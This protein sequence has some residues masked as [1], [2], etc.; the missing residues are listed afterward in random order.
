LKRIA[1]IH[2]PN[3]FPWL[4][5]FDKI[6]RADAFIFLDD[7]Q[8]AKKGG[9]WTNRVKLQISGEARWITAPVQRNFHGSKTINEMKFGAHPQWR[10]K[11]LKSIRAN[12]CSAPYY[13]EMISFFQEVIGNEESNVAS[14]N[15]RAILEIAK[16]LELNTDHIFWSSKLEHHGASNEL[17][18]SLTKAVGADTYLFGGGAGGYQDEQVFVNEGIGL[19]AQ[20]FHHPEYPQNK[21][22]EFL[23]G[24]SIIDAVANLGWE[25]TAMI[26]QKTR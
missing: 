12:Y 25:A 24:L 26:L 5:Y 8:F 7:V 1:A 6:A 22:A 10:G 2:Q 18:V 17:L 20:N 16:Q 11:I 3:F 13:D 21:G 19:E 9:T 14:Y 23:P 4:G 15:C